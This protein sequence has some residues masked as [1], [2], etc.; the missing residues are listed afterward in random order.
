MVTVYMRFIREILKIPKKIRAGI[1]YIHQYLKMKQEILG[2]NDK[3]A[4]R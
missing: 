1:I 2:K 4:G 3:I